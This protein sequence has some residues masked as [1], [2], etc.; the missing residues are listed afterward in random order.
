MAT[1]VLVAGSAMPITIRNGTTV[2][3]IST[4]GGF[5]EGGGLVAERLAVFEDGVEHHAEHG[6]ED[7]HDDDHHQRV[8]AVD[9]SRDLRCR[10]LQVQLVH[11]R[12][13]GAAGRGLVINSRCCRGTSP[14]RVRGGDGQAEHQR[15]KSF[16]K[17]HVFPN[18][19]KKIN[20][21]ASSPSHAKHLKVPSLCLTKKFMKRLCWN[22]VIA[23]DDLTSAV[24]MLPAR[25]RLDAFVWA[26][27][28]QN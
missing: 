4:G 15:L 17:F 8:Q 23:A 13:A 18:H 27:Y 7:H 2:Q 25:E 22:L 3:A 1:T 9:I 26:K 20:W 28:W 10:R 11:H 16:R 14:R 6:N 12:T 5:M 24:A 19:P 21:C